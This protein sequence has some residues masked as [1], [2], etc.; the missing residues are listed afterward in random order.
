MPRPTSF[1]TLYDECKTINIT[2]LK[3]WG[4]LKPNQLASGELSWKR[5]GVNTGNIGISSN[6]YGFDPF[7]ELNYTY[8]NETRIQ[9]RVFLISKPANIGRGVVWFFVCPKTGKYCR[10]LYL[11]GG[12]FYHRSAFAGCMY[13]KQ[14]MSHK[15]RELDQLFKKAFGD[16]NVFEQI[17]KKHFK[18]TY[19]GKPTKRYLKLMRKVKDAETINE[20]E[21]MAGILSK[22]R[23]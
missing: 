1:P 11:I 19:A 12:Y 14:T 5:N 8:N 13:E 21:L 17:T 3:K 16:G 2:N 20:A 4:Y 10:K 7:I 18:K 23:R 9:Y 6:T 22:R 15:N